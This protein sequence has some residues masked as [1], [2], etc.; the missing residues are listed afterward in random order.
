M[1]APQLP[2]VPAM[3]RIGRPIPIMASLALAFVANAGTLEAQQR[4]E[5]VMRRTPRAESADSTERQL[6]RLQ[7]QLDSL[8]RI[9]IESDQLTVARRRRVEEELGATVERLNELSMRL[10]GP[11]DRSPRAPEAVRVFVAP[12]IRGSTDMS[13]ALMQ[14]REAEAAM[15]RG[16]IGIVAQGPGLEP[17]I[18]DGELIVRYFSY[19]RIVSVD[20]SSP[21][22][23][24]GVIPSDTLI[25]YNGRDVRENDISITRLL[26]PSARLTVRVLRD[27]KLRDIPMTVAAAPPRIVLRRGDEVRVAREPWAASGVPDAPAFPRTAMPPMASGGGGMV[28]SSTARV[29]SEGAAPGMI[30]PAAAPTAGARLATGF[31]FQVTGVAGAQM[32]TITEGLAQ[33]IGVSSG[34]LVTSVPVGT[35]AS[36]SGLRDG[37][38]IVKADGRSIASVGQVRAIV[39]MANDNAERE[40]ILEVLRNKKLQ[41]LTLRW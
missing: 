3:S 40:V 6:R 10:S 21:A 36:E 9:Y 27:G 8:T 39:G 18:E 23:R 14:V 7:H 38:V 11:G 33:T 26:K 19:P 34:V 4:T 32:T 24:A 41:K 2:P 13:R 5:I 35:P 15:P 12:G 28:M 30:A 25:A 16:W 20:P 31:T 1:P 22:Q 37:D 17:R 29:R